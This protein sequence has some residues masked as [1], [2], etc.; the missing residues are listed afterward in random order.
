[1]A[2]APVALLISF[3]GLIVD[4]RKKYAL[5]GALLSGAMGAMILSLVT[6]SMC[7]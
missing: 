1:M 4:Q 7:R 3:A 6:L 5:G 2:A